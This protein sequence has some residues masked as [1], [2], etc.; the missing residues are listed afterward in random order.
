MNRDYYTKKEVQILLR[1]LKEHIIRQLSPI[2]DTIEPEG[3]KLKI[4]FDEYEDYSLFFKGLLE[5]E[6]IRGTEW[7]F[8]KVFEEGLWGKSHGIEWIANKNLCIYLFDTLADHDYIDPKNMMKKIE[9]IFGIKHGHKI[10]SKYRANLN[11]LPRGYEIVDKALK[12]L[13]VQRVIENIGDAQIDALF[14]DGYFDEEE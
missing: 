3:F 9:N 11:Y 5:Y 10:R 6:L 14:E 12:P 8:Q 4:R 1:K 2:E 7:D 13:F